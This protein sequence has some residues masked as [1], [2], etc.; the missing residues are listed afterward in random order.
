MIELIKRPVVT[1]KAMRLG[2]L[3]QY[4]FIVDPKANKVE[5]KKAV[6]ELF[7]VDVLSVRTMKVKG[8]MKSRFT[9]TGV[10]RGQAPLR[11]KAI[12]TLKEGQIIDLVSGETSE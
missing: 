9:K 12:V 6:E 5:I 4:V 2:E 10:M 11:K 1:E 7:E 3:G 8:K